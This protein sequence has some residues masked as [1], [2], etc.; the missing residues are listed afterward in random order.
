MRNGF[1][2]PYANVS[3]HTASAGAPI[4]GLPLLL[5]QLTPFPPLAAVYGLPAGAFPF[6]LNRISFPNKFRM[7][8]ACRKSPPSPIT[9]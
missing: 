4:G 3:S 5:R 6:K 2:K 1:R 9:R 8:C 7:S